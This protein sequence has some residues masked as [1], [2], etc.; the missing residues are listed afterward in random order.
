MSTPQDRVAVACPSCSPEEP[1]VHEVLKPGGQAT[2]RC[3]E[4]SH[5]HKVRIEEEREVQRDVIVSQ[6]QESFKTTVDAPAEETIA[7]GEEFIVDTEEAIMLVRITGI[8]VGP[9][10]R[11]E[12][13]EVE[14]ATTIWTR[15]VDNVSVNVTV[16][17]KDGKHDKTRSFK[18]H[19]PGDYEFVVGETEE[20]GDEKFTVK[21]LHVREDAP[22]YRHGKLDHDGDMVY[23]KDLNRLY[24]RDETSTAW[25]A[26]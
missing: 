15:A 1:T 18:V 14:D 7:V 2:V 5:V 10:Q 21:A 9:E 17:P 26:W 20:F 19:V 22:E 11:T 6:D 8:E 16:N 25:S 4:C 24:G 3:T 13:A 12:S 23:A